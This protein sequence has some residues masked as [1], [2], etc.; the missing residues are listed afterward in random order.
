[1]K[2]NFDIFDFV[3]AEEDMQ[4]IT[5]IDEEQ[6]LIFSHYDP[7]LVEMIISYKPNI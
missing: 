7:K 3:L 2:Q 5:K 4:H 6:S 1:M